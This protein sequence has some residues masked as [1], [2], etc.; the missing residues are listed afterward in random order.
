MKRLIVLFVLTVACAANLTAQ[1]ILTADRFLASVGERY[2][3]I[4]DYEAKISITTSKAEMRGTISHKSPGLLRIDFLKP[5]E[6]VIVFNGE[7]LT[8]YLPEYRAVLS[9]S[10]SGEKKASGASL[11][12]AQGLSIMRRNYVAAY[13]SGPDPV[14]LDPDSAE[15]VIVLLL[16]RRSLSEGFRELKISVSP[17]TL[18]IRR[19]EGKTI[20]EEFVSF[21]FT[22]M[23]LDQGIPE[24]RFS[25]DS[26]ASANLFNNFLFNKG[27]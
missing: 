15:Q 16:T 12:S 9:Q 24:M 17:E 2:A 3:A 22:D 10:V 7:T 20:A 6:Q 5:E 19:I 1:D 23:K 11:A 26:P 21:D 18:L 13:A 27:E 25:Y 4:K 14:P 8:V